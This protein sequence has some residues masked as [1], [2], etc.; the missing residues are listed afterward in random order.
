MTDGWETRIGWVG[1][2]ASDSGVG[3]G[4]RD[5][6]G[7]TGGIATP[8]VETRCSIQSRGLSEG[9]YAGVAGDKRGAIPDVFS[10]QGT[11]H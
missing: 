4:E 8:G 9:E 5:S 6:T 7:A 3:W 1:R 2:G 10:P 11:R